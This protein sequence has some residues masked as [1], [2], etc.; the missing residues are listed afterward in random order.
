ML[1]DFNIPAYDSVTI[2]KD[3]L[4]KYL[5]KKAHTCVWLAA[6]AFST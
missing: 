5:I 4:F 6:M 1:F 3:Y 2:I